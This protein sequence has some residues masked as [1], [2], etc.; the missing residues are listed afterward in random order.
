M[1][2]IPQI[3]IQDYSYALPD[4]RVPLRPLTQRDDSKLLSYRDGQITDQG[5]TDLPRLLPQGCTLV[6]NN[7]RVLAARIKFAKTTGGQIEVFCLE[8]M[9]SS[10]E[11]ALFSKGTSQW[12]CLIGGASKWKPGQVLEKSVEVGSRIITL[13][14]KY[15]SKEQGGFVI[16]FSWQPEEI[17]FAEILNY[18]GVIPLPPYIKREAELA[19]KERY[20]T[21]FSKE[22]GS[23]AAPTAALHFTDN[24]L[25]ELSQKNINLTYLTLHV[26][27]GTFQPVKSEM[28]AGHNMHREFFLVNPDLVQQLIEAT[29]IAAVGTTSFRT[30]ETLYWLG[31]KAFK[32]LP[33]NDHSF[34]QWEAYELAQLYPGITTKDA[35]TALLTYM[36]DLGISTLEGDT[37]LLVMPSYKVRVPQALITNFHQPQSTLLLLIAAFVGDN[38]RKIYDHALQ[39]GYRFLSYGDSSLLWKAEQPG[40]M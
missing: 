15:L 23:V 24:I 36:N 32:H 10:V 26:G 21:I 29:T 5:F 9:N 22:Q 14:A 20:Q 2:E 12:R 17:A 11:S 40:W 25:R 34:T 27:A 6:L 7:T 35:L 30:L 18:A 8:P 16:Q 19:D 38:W 31:V 4:E 33:M 13:E 3:S 1:P 39:N 28:I 37:S